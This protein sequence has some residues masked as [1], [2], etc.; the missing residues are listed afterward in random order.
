MGTARNVPRSVRFLMI[1]CY[2]IF[3]GFWESPP[4]GWNQTAT[5]QKPQKKKNETKQHVI[6]NNETEKDNNDDDDDGDGH[7][8]ARR[9]ARCPWPEKWR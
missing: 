5:D 2:F 7:D 8:D 9:A 3:C 4:D 6:I 1:L